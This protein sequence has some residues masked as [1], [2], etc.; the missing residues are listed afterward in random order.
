MSDVEEMVGGGHSQLENKTVKTFV[1]NG[2]TVSVR[3]RR[4]NQ[5]KDILSNVDGVVNA[6]DL[7][8]IMGPSCVP[9][10]IVESP[11]C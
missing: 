4:S 10:E 1:W 3:D 6:G 2:A 9:D 8:A 11:A 5:S 7:L